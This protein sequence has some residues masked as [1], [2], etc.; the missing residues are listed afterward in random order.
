VTY[1][2]SGNDTLYGSG[3]LDLILAGAGA[4]FILGDGRDGPHPAIYPEPFVG[5][6]V[7][8]NVIGAG[9]GN[10]TVFAG[11]GTDTVHGGAGDD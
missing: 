7:G 1:G 2:T 9:D 3:A 11:Y 8:G 10:D 6:P 5:L 4:D